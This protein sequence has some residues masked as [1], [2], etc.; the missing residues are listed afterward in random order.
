MG[1]LTLP[2]SCLYILAR[3]LHRPSRLQEEHV[4]FLIIPRNKLHLDILL[5]QTESGIGFLISRS[6]PAITAHRLDIETQKDDT[7]EGQNLGGGEMASGTESS[8]AP[9]WAK[10][11]GIVFLGFQKSLV[12][13]LMH[14]VTPSRR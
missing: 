14:I 7:G 1:G 4:P 8:S 11:D 10:C 3:D 12:V 6:L 5:R 13:E 2:S 9:K